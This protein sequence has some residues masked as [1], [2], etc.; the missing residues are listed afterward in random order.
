LI[1]AFLI[2]I[3]VANGDSKMAYTID[4]ILS[5]PGITVIERNDGIGEYAIRIGELTTTVIIQLRWTM[6]R[7]FVEF[8]Q[9]HAIKTPT[10]AGPYRG[11]R[12]FDDDPAYAL[13]RAVSGI[14]DYYNEAVRA[15][16]VPREDWLV[17]NRV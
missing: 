9:S 6:D 5:E 17:E 10:Q 16:H 13:H 12:P 3:S 11:S 4:Q 14:T 7:K 2:A 15:G 1:K 8:T